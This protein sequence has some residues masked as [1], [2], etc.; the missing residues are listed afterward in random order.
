M[1]YYP[2]LHTH[3]C[4]TWIAGIAIA[5]MAV[6]FS[7]SAEGVGFLGYPNLFVNPEF[8]DASVPN[9]S[10]NGRWGWFK[11]ERVT[12][13]G[14]TGG[15]NAGVAAKSDTNTW[16]PVLPGTDNYRAF[17]QMQDGFTNGQSWIEQTVTPEKSGLYAFTC[18]YATRSTGNG[19]Y[20]NP[21]MI[22]FSIA[23]GHVTNEFATVAFSKNYWTY[24]NRIWY[25]PL[26]GGQPYSFRIYGKA[27]QTTD[28]TALIGS[29]SLEYLPQPD[30]SITGE[31]RLT[32]DEDWT[33][34]TVLLAPGARVHLD[35]HSLRMNGS[36]R[37]ELN[38]AEPLFTD[39]MSNPGELRVT[40]PAG[41]ESF[42][43]GYSIGGGI[44][45]VK[46]GPGKFTWSGGTIAATVPITVTGGV[47]KVNVKTANV[48]GS[49]GTVTVKSPAQFDLNYGSGNNAPTFNRTFYFEGEGP[50]GSGALVNTAT[51]GKS[52]SHFNKAYMTGDATIGGTSRIDFRGNNRL[53]EGT[54]YTLTIKNRDMVAFCAGSAYLY[55]A[56]VIA[57]DGGVFQPCNDGGL[58]NISG[59][60]YLVNGGVLASWAPSNANTYQYT[61]S[62]IV[63]AGGGT[64]RS[65]NNYFKCNQPVTVTAGQ[66][67]TIGARGTWYGV[68]TNET[69]ASI[70]LTANN[71]E[72]RNT[73]KLVNR[74]LVEQRAGELRFG[75][76]SNAAVSCRVENDGTIRTTGGKFFFNAASVAVGS[77]VFDLGG[78]SDVA[79]DLSGFTGTIRISGGWAKLTS[80][81]GFGGTLILADGVISNSLA[82]AACPVV[83]D[84]S[85][86]TGP[87]T[88]PESWLTLPANKAV[89]IDLRGRTL[90]WG[91]QIVAWETGNR[92]ALAFS[93]TTYPFVE[94]ADGLYLGDGDVS[95]VATA[96]WTD[97][98]GNGEFADPG[99]WTCRDSLDNP[100]ATFPTPATAITLGAD[101]PFGGW[102]A[103]DPSVQTGAIDL[104]G[105]RLILYP[106]NA[107]AA[108]F[109][110][111]DTSA[112]TAQP[113]ELHFT[114][115]KGVNFSKTADLGITGNLSLVVDG[116]GKFTW[117][118]GTLAATIPITITGGVFKVGVTNEHVLGT[119]GT[120]TIKGSGQFDIN[121]GTHMKSSPIRERTFYIEGAG[122]DGS[123]AIVNTSSGRQAG[124]HL[125]KVIM[126]GDAT[127][128]GP[129][130]IDFRGG[131]YGI[132]GA[133]YTLTIKNTGM[134]AFCGS[135]TYL[136]C[137]NVIAVDGGYF[138][139][140]YGC[141]L[142]ISGAV[143]LVNGGLFAN[144]ADSGKTQEFNF[145]VFVG[146]GGG[147]FKSDAR[148]YKMKKPVVV[149]S[150]STLA[151]TTETPWYTA[152]V[153]NQANASLYIGGDFFA[154]GGIFANDG[155]VEHTGGKLYFGSRDDTTHPCRVENNGTIRATGGNFYF[156]SES[157]AFGA[158][159]FEMAG[160]T[161]SLAG[162]FTG[163]T[164]TILLK[165]GTTSFGKPD[166]FSGTLVLR[167]GAFA[168][169][170]SLAGFPGTATISLKDRDLPFDV[171]GKN[172]FTFAP[173][174]EV[175]VDTGLRTFEKGDQLL[176]W[177]TPPANH[178]R[179]ILT[180]GQSNGVLCTDATGLYFRT[181]GFVISIR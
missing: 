134:L 124:Y 166:T 145:P 91:E 157:S 163:F 136:R 77:G 79:G 1:R 35:G 125:N 178:V 7:A 138:Q 83:F 43:T 80:L 68:V 4:N 64:I 180:N 25:L 76:N 119:S 130:R 146:A 123:G 156:K 6:A 22:G 3:T 44:R 5:S 72:F 116:E 38:A 67:L 49:S 30:L 133:G 53:L 99:N 73:E 31:Y 13:T 139:P 42:N 112:N 63:G 129:S 158:G 52:G 12:L 8:E 159:T 66:T 122:P 84:L 109:S 115:G 36:L 106:T 90:K 50:D 41:V 11:D 164:G 65:D 151:C 14:W 137:D 140:C 46:D 171:D 94:K 102:T 144:W 48:F 143:T 128:G 147:I 75:H 19:T 89:T 162:D 160:G 120:V 70:V 86:K 59:S 26:E 170:T 173:G 154:A 40:V 168:S 57:T 39:E 85:G 23:Y 135:S 167:D 113:G 27:D 92:P 88:I 174:K 10:N 175:L 121:Y 69:G 95:D 142:N 74:G 150:G 96:T 20:G 60:I 148:W 34:A 100:V 132:E 2:P 54:G 78:G 17:I 97:A 93:S 18:R 103:F 56:N 161:P 179:F 149:E 172:W 165:G 45:F 82:D 71:T 55:C 62:V 181:N 155:F 176:S 16:L 33:D 21:G 153:T 114:L 104:N 127:I 98:K 61:N 29:C 24:Q 15:G 28:R 32:A 110:V 131:N 108:A 107:S 47:F 118:G 87:F 141:T 37:L 9:T 111:T 81:A 169:G 51:D 177:T 101:V 152:P 58:V 105:H 126:T 117:S